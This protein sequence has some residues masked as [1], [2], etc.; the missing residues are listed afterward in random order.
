VCLGRAYQPGP[1]TIR[2]DLDAGAVDARLTR[3]TRLRVQ[4]L[5]PPQRNWIKSGTLSLPAGDQVQQQEA[6]FG[7]L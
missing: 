1:I 3:L 7:R 5:P 2:I 4:M 6:G